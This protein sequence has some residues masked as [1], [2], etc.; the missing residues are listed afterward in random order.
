MTDQP[1]KINSI[2]IESLA[3]RTEIQEIAERLELHSLRLC[4]NLLLTLDDVVQLLNTIPPHITLQLLAEAV[5]I[6]E[7]NKTE[8]TLPPNLNLMVSKLS[9][10]N[11]KTDDKEK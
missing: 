3:E 10:L 8:N 9:Q 11:I 5:K 7:T 6:R 1:N 2:T 4:K